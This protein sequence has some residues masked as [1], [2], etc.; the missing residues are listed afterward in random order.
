MEMRKYRDL[1]ND[2]FDLNKRKKD[3]VLDARQKF[4]RAMEELANNASALTSYGE[5]PNPYPNRC[6]QSGKYMYDAKL[7]EKTDL[8]KILEAHN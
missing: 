8:E 7:Q 3:C 1:K 5:M 4:F 6:Y 2:N